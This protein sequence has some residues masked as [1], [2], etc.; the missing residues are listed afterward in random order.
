MAN[1]VEDGMAWQSMETAPRDGTPILVLG[2]N[3]ERGI[4][5]LILEEFD[6]LKIE[7]SAIAY[8][9]RRPGDQETSVF[10]PSSSWG[11]LVAWMPYPDINAL[12]DTHTD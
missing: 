6:G 3:G 4:G 9:H 7:N 10:M 8:C 5:R 11:D 2:P 1:R 12:S